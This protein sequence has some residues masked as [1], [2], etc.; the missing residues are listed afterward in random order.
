MRQF[1]GTTCVAMLLLGLSG[2]GRTE[3][4]KDPSAIL[5][6]AIKALGG[7]E[8]LN[9]VKAVSW[10]TKGTLT[11][12]GSDNEFT[13]HSTAKGL[14][15]FR[16]EFEGEF[17]GNKIKAVTVVKGDK[18]WRRFMDQT[19][20]MDE[21]AL[22]NEHRNIALQVIPI[23]LVALKGKGY[24]LEVAGEEKVEGKPAVGLKITPPKGEA[25]TLYF[26][27]ESGLPVRQVAKLLDFM[28]TEYTQDTIMDKYKE[29]DGIKKAT[30]ISNKRDGEKFIDIEITEFKVL[31]KVDPKTFDQP[32]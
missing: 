26:D 10:K 30:K 14:D 20:D 24:K 22:A 7:E 31:D 8:K 12:N 21:S 25:Y 16:S 18:G 5:D 17:G 32:E 23:T 28:G 3:D 13:S 29:I 2:L 19:M 11:I 6:K 4:A 15:H 27:K 9:A 1:I